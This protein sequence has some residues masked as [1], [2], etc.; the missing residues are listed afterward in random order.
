MLLPLSPPDHDTN[1]Q[2]C[3]AA[4]QTPSGTKSEKPEEIARDYMEPVAVK[5]IRTTDPLI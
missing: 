3:L 4:T 2:A 1:A 5:A